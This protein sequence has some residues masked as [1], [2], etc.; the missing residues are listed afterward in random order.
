M[1]K[2][3]SVC[4]AFLLL[5]STTRHA[6]ATLF[7]AETFTLQNGLQVIVIPNHKAPIVK[8]MLWY[9]AGSADEELGKGGSAHLLEH[10]MFRGTK[11]VK[12]RNFN[13]L[14]EQNGADSNAFTSLDY[15]AYHQSLDISKLELAMA[16]EADR[17]RNLNISPQDF[18]LER[19]IVFQ[20]RKQ[21]VE[22]NP[23]AP[24][25][26]SFRKL[27]WQDTPYGRPVTGTE[28]EIKALELED[29]NAFYRR[30]YA[31]NNAILILSGDIDLSTAKQL[32]EKYYGSAKAAE[33][34]EKAEFRPINPKIGAKLSMALPGINA[35]RV[36][37]TYIAPSYNTKPEDIYNLSVLSKYLGEGETSEL[38]KKLVVD[39][40]LALSVST[41]YNP[42]SRG[43]GTFDISALPAVGVNADELNKAID[44]ELAAAVKRLNIDEIEKIKQ[45]ML[46]GLVYLRD[47]PFEAAMIVGYM[48]VSGMSVNEIEEYADK[49]NAVRY[50]DVKAAA[51]RLFNHSASFRGVL[52]PQKSGE[53]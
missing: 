48:S 46:S 4:L 8:Q 22:N 21:V 11:K 1:K 12:G 51:D 28:D 39:R 44:E 40:K 19:D 5:L 42:F 49:I 16:L 17:M 33:I 24:F 25:S 20:E 45:K 53:K 2:I 27:V 34:G 23:A 38:Y 50:Q 3:H 52:S 35:E 30:F 41:S 10:L 7:G 37:R 13:A 18:A 6:S 47:N 9:K 29:V 32:A 26:E 14:L 31:P 36:S 43:E 15:T